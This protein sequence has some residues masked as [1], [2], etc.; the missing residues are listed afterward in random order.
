MKSKKVSPPQQRWIKRWEGKIQPSQ[1]PHSSNVVSD[2][3][4]LARG[5][6]AKI[7]WATKAKSAG[8]VSDFLIFEPF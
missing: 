2:T 7:G 3:V 8:R 6:A 1:P 4:T 5:G